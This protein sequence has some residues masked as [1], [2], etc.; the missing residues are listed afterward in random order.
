MA[1]KKEIEVKAANA[2]KRIAAKAPRLTDKQIHAKE[3]ARQRE[4]AYRNVT[5]L[6][7]WPSDE[8]E[9]YADRVLRARYYRGVTDRAL[10]YLTKDKTGVDPEFTDADELRE[11]VTQDCDGAQEVIYTARARMV[12]YVS[13]FAADAV[14][15][16]VDDLGTE[17]KN[18]TPELIAFAC[19]EHDVLE[20]IE[21]ELGS[22]VAEWFKNRDD[23]EGES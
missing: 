12:G 11:R 23:E 21:R 16:L 22:D 13:D 19:L 1:S 15:Y 5:N 10:S 9:D 6:G 17:A 2:R 8:D 20:A 3:A 14:E 4:E 7:D 18:L